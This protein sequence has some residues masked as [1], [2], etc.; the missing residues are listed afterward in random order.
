MEIILL[1]KFSNM[2]KA[3]RIPTYSTL[4]FNNYQLIANL[5]SSISGVGKL[6]AWDKI[7]PSICFCKQTFI[8]TQPHSFVYLPPMAAFVLNSRVE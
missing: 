3:E 6:W 5:A 1:W 8:A 2:H 4:S 7:Q